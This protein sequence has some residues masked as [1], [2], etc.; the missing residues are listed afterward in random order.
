MLVI[1]F[2]WFAK[3]F[4]EGCETFPPQQPL[5]RLKLCSAKSYDRQA[6]PST[7]NSP[8]EIL[9]T[10][11]THTHKLEG[12]TWIVYPIYN[13]MF[14]NGIERISQEMRQRMAFLSVSQK[15]HISVF[16]FVDLPS[17]HSSSRR[18]RIN[19]SV[20]CSI[21]LAHSRRETWLGR[22]NQRWRGNIDGNEWRIYNL[23]WHG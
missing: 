5:P 19:N 21:K 16:V 4:A 1:C 18:G 17:Q 20:F 22:R 9:L 15:L 3:Y 6:E 14:D 23:P 8:K 7:L 12:R 13:I 10:L 2:H 11:H